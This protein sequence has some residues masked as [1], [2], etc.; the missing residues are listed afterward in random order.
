MSW[1]ENGDKSRIGIL[2]NGRTT[3]GQW[4]MEGRTCKL[5]LIHRHKTNK[6][7]KIHTIASA[8]HEGKLHV[9]GL[10]E[11]RGTPGPQTWPNWS[12][13]SNWTYVSKAGASLCQQIRPRNVDRMQPC[14]G[15]INSAS[16]CPLR[17][18]PLHTVRLLC[19]NGWCCLCL[20]CL[21]QEVGSDFPS[22][23]TNRYS[24]AKCF[25]ALFERSCDSRAHNP[26]V[27]VKNRIGTQAPEIIQHLEQ[28]LQVT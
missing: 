20:L 9:E 23:A 5:A 26:S 16:S 1:C 3:S 7:C 2:K 6:A 13:G 14:A 22:S 24:V 8:F 11:V 15:T 18:L 19:S 12:N 4:W 25:M 21:C 17:P 27:L 10:F 28:P